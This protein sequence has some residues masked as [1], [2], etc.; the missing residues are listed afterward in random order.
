MAWHT[1]NVAMRGSHALCQHKALDD[2]WCACLMALWQALEASRRCTP[3]GTLA[4]PL[5]RSS[6]CK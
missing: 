5:V 2:P 3:L 4:T 1:E 6:W